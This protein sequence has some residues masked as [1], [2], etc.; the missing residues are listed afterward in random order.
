MTTKM[1]GASTYALAQRTYADLAGV[2]FCNIPSQVAL[3]RSPDALN[4]YKNYLSTNGQAIET[5]PGITNLGATGSH[6]Y[7][8]HILGT[9]CLIHYGTNLSKWDTF[10][11]SIEDSGDLDSSLHSM[12]EATST[13]FVFG[14]KLYINDGV[15]YLA[16]DGATLSE[17]KADATIP[18][19]R[20]AADPDGGNGEL[21]QEINLLSP[22]RDNSFIGD[23]SST[24][25]YLD[26]TGLDDSGT[27]TMQAWINGNLM[28]EGSGFTVN[29]TTGVV[30]FSSAP[31]SPSTTGT[32]NVVIRY[33]KTVSANVL[34]IENCTLTKTF[35]NRVFFSG[36]EDHPGMIFH[37]ELDDPS[38]IRETAYYIDGE[39]SSN[40]KALIRGSGMLI[41]VKEDEGNGAKVLIHTPSLNSS[42]GKIYPVTSTEISL[43]AIGF[44]LN[45]FDDIVFLSPMGLEVLRFSESSV[46]LDH[47]STMIDRKL[48]SE[49]DLKN[50]QTAVWNNYL[51]MLINGKIYLADHRQIFR[52][53]QSAE[54]EWYVWDN[55]GVVESDTLQEATVLA[56]YE[57]ELYI[58]CKNRDVAVFNGLDDEGRLIESYWTTPPDD[59]GAPARLKS[60][61]RRGGI[62]QIKRI[63]NSVIKLD[64]QTDKESWVNVLRSV[65]SGFTFAEYPFPGEN[66]PDE[67]TDFSFGTGV[68]GKIVYRFNRRRIKDISLKFYSDEIGKPFGLYEATLQAAIMNYTR[69]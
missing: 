38:Y 51:L 65:S 13:S 26:A 35:D 17:V 14:D 36:N 31:S 67:I 49:S 29:R 41:V 63:S 3:N 61:I 21:Y 15:N 7:G 8:L 56:T 45:F 54:Y 59:F 32:D 27:Y 47:R 6:I 48:I 20:I 1:S 28:T 58:G 64:V 42:I 19:T 12:N 16:Y 34:K 39:D 37:S 55:I 10:P 33:S 53:E 62:A 4:I 18:T 25:Y 52:G 66:Y 22:Y 24:A 40:I 23:G 46:A 43:G 9:K 44:G 30:T 50:C 2:D 60:V 57:G 68:R 5:R 69:K 11:S